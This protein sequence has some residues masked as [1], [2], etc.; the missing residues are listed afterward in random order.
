MQPQGYDCFVAR[1]H[2]YF[3][4]AVLIASVNAAGYAAYRSLPPADG[5][6]G[7]AA[8][9]SN[10]PLEATG[11]PQPTVPAPAMAEPIGSMKVV[12]TP[13]SVA[14][15]RASAH[16]TATGEDTPPTD[17][18]DLANRPGHRASRAVAEHDRDP[19][20]TRRARRPT[21]RDP[22]R[23]TPPR[24]APEKKVVKAPAEKAVSKSEP[25]TTNSATT[26]KSSAKKDS[27]S[28]FLKVEENPYKRND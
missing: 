4:S 6:A 13:D 25:A 1:W 12:V 9:S 8:A 14:T 17:D 20:N 15:E 27:E 11:Q 24:A 3:V 26:A 10:V 22:V 19:H 18:A 2:S 21:K 7:E 23:S 16:G 28:R 5:I